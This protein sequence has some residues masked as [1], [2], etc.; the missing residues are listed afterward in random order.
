MLAR[1]LTPFLFG[2]KT[3]SRRPPAPEMTLV[4]RGSFLLVLDAPVTAVEDLIAQGPLTAEVFAETDEEQVGE[5]LYGV[6]FADLKLRAEVLLLGSCHAPGGKP[7]TECPV[8]SRVG[9]WSKM[10]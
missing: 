9:G 1:N 5:C 7:V 6:D 4:V 2:A 8:L 10:L 3:C